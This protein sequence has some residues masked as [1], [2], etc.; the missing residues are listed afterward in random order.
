MSFNM[1]AWFYEKPYSNSN[2]WRSPKREASSFCPDHSW[3]LDGNKDCCPVVG[4]RGAKARMDKRGLGLNSDELEPLD[5]FCEPRRFGW[6]SA[7]N[8]VG[9]ADSVNVQYAE[10]ACLSLRK[11]PGRVRVKPC[12]L[13]WAHCGGALKA[14]VWAKT[15]GEASSALDASAR[16][17]VEAS[18]LCVSSSSRGA[19]QAVSEGFKKNLRPWIRRKPWSFRTRQGLPCI[20]AWVGVGLVSASGCGWPRPVSIGN[21]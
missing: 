14:A 15:N 21:V 1:L 20:R 13:G 10:G 8:S 5:S 9:P 16:V 11:E 19:D 12:S 18:R 17:S 6:A 2:T 3:G 4:N 7:S